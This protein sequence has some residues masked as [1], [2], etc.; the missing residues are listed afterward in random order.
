MTV[1]KLKDKIRPDIE[2]TF[3]GLTANYLDI[4]P[5]RY[6]YMQEKPTK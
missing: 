3:G 5:V 6:T 1:D 2:S 4:A